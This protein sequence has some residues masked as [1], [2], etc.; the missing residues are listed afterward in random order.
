M[1]YFMLDDNLLYFGFDNGEWG[2]G[3][4]RLNIRDGS[5]GEVRN[6]FQGTNELEEFPVTSMV[7]SP[8]HKHCLYVALSLAHLDSRTG[9]V[10]LVCDGHTPE[11]IFAR[12]APGGESSFPNGEKMPESVLYKLASEPITRLWNNQGRIEIKTWYG[13]YQLSGPRTVVIIEQHKEMRD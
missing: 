5:V 2:G 9:R 3:L 7:R 12:I 4:Y 11:T 13:T 10:V 8:W 6:H 1:H